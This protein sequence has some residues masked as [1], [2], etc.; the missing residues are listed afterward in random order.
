[1]A[2][3]VKALLNR[4]NGSP[5]SDDPLD[6]IR[7]SLKRREKLIARILTFAPLLRNLL[8]VVGLLYTIALP[9]KGLGRRHYISENALQP[10][11][12]RFPFLFPSSAFAT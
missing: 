5:P 3:L 7:P 1:M 12:V 4:K 11:H 2:S 6:A 8:V 10:G 9:Y